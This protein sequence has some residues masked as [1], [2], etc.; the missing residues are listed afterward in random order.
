MDLVIQALVVRQNERVALLKG[1]LTCSCHEPAYFQGLT[2]SHSEHVRGRY[3]LRHQ[4]ALHTDTMPLKVQ[5]KVL[6][7]S[8]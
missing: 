1:G 3:H 6:P 4:Q 7:G 2:L 5:S 8:V